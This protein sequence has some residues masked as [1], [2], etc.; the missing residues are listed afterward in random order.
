M[1]EKFQINPFDRTALNDFRQLAGRTEEFRQVRFILRNS[2][3]NKNRIRSIL[4]TGER[5]VGKTS[6]LNLIEAECEVNNIIPIRI[7]LTDTNS[8]NSCDFFWHLFSQAL[9]SLFNFG[10]FEGKGGA[11]DVMIQQ[12]LNSDGISDQANW[13]FSTPVLRRNYLTNPNT[14]FEFHLFIEDIRL[15]R[16]EVIELGDKYPENTKLLF[17]VDESQHLYSNK[18]IVEEIRFVLQSQDL[19]VGFVFAG[20][21]EYKKAEWE[22][23]FGGSYREFEVV[24]LPFFNSSNSVE[25]YFKKSLSTIGWTDQEIEETFFYRFKLSCRHI[26]YLTSGK[27]SWINVI[28]SKMFERCMLGEVRQLRFDKQAHVLAP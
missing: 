16:K 24:N 4:I 28:A 25:E 26:F 6:F 13:V 15:M 12:I 11:I 3:K 23:V 18:Q 2:V 9:N 21:N 1:N 22:K 19:G 20:D 7:N 5:G 27:P 14:N 8:S 10:L 17:L